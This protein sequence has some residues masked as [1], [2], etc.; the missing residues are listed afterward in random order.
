MRTHPV[1]ILTVATVAAA[2]LAACDQA[3]SPT[4]AGLGGQTAASG[5]IGN[6]VPLIISPTVVQLGVGASF[7]FTTNAPVGQQGQVQWNS[8][9]S[10]V[11]T[12]S[13]S[14]LVNAVAAGTAV[15]VARFSFDTTNVAVATVIVSGTT[16]G[17]TTSSSTPGVP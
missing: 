17:G 13:P 15:I 7:Q 8:L 5:T 3:T 4:I 14:G 11:A 1:L 9:Q 2:A 10:T 12:V 16:T 6:A